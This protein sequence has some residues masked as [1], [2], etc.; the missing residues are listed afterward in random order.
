MR[1][2]LAALQAA[3]DEGVC[4]PGSPTARG[5]PVFLLISLGP[6]DPNSSSVDQAGR[7]RHE[8][9][10]VDRCRVMMTTPLKDR[11]ILLGLK[12]EWSLVCL[13]VQRRATQPVSNLQDPSKIKLLTPYSWFSEYSSCV[14]RAEMVHTVP[15]S[16]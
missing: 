12:V 13:R 4:H 8:K 2:V 5:L 6:I 14:A 10:R 15:E 9:L 1:P 16:L 3:M 7:N 11:L